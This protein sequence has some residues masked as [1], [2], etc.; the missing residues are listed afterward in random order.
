MSGPV[1]ASLITALV[2]LG[3]PGVVLI[4]AALLG[5]SPFNANAD[6]ASEPIF[7]ALDQPVASSS[8]G[9][10]TALSPAIESVPAPAAP[11][12]SD[13]SSTVEP[14]TSS[15]VSSPSIT[16]SSEPASTDTAA[17]S[18][19]T[20]SM[21]ATTRP[22][23][24][25]PATRVVTTQGAAPTTGASSSVAPSNMTDS[26]TALPSSASVQ[27]LSAT[28]SRSVEPL[29]P[30]TGWPVVAAAASFVLA[31]LATFASLAHWLLPLRT[32]TPATGD[33]P[34][35]AGRI[36]QLHAVAR[37]FGWVEYPLLILGVASE[38]SLLLFQVVNRPFHLTLFSLYAALLLFQLLQWN[39]R[40][41]WGRVVSPRQQP[42]ARAIVRCS[43]QADGRLIA[44]TTTARDGSFQLRVPAGR[45]DVRAEAVPFTPTL[46]VA[47]L[48]TINRARISLV[49]TP[50][51]AEP[52]MT[53]V[54]RP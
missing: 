17:P 44:A 46:A 16:E 10:S 13:S 4:V 35:I 41:I 25:T 9:G 6:T 45:Y 15:S 29:E 7:Y 32:R 33:N 18:D 54:G 30:M 50:H 27:P 53:S 28:I 42:I 48:E 47:D 5:R 3:V 38:T 43:N 36:H 40:A 19:V 20:E 39:K 24:T 1:R 21:A 51:L 2:T 26:L 8:V 12:S 22:P 14:V 11:L 49:L 34:L 52:T 31:L 37:G 23:S